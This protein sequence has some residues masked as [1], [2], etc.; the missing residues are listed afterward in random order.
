MV[1]WSKLPYSVNQAPEHGELAL[2]AA[3]ESLVL[4]KNQGLLPLSKSVKRI[5]VIGPTADNV[6]ALLG[7]YNGTPAAPVTIL[8][9]IRA[10]VPNAEVTYERGAELVE[11]FVERT[12][13]AASGTPPPPAPVPPSADA[14][15]AAARNADV[16]IFV[17]GLTSQI[18]GEEM[19]VSYPGFSG[20]DRTDLNLPASQQQLLEALVA[21][22]KPVVLVLTSGSALAVNWAQ[23]RVPAILMS[24]YPGQSG[25]TAVADVLFGGANPGGRL[26][27]TFYKSIDELP[28][29]DD[30]RM[31]G[32]TYRYFRGE[33][34]YPFGFGLSYTH[35][36]YSDLKLDR[37]RVGRTGKLKISVRV[38]NTGER[39]GDEVVQLYLRAVDTPHAR[40][41]RE[42]RGF[43]RI[44]L[45]PGEQRV[46]SFEI[47]PA[48]DLRYY[49][50]GARDYAVDPGT[51]EVQV[52]ASSADTR[53]VHSFTVRR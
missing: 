17:G 28:A 32:R 40:A 30:Y 33:P 25:G 27:V 18:E 45:Q 20:G 7:N 52:G 19:R 53:L 22:G 36:T 39:T 44:S 10:A 1:P 2:R 13:P 31:D 51:Y 47:S 35:F 48:T 49:D 41:N 42:L 26:P 14:A 9:G 29:F 23:Q 38:Q 50:E 21:T 24:W 16:V 15:L 11:G 6:P 46:V 4:L 43:Q 12:P 5:A 37:A 8:Q 34:L 3:H